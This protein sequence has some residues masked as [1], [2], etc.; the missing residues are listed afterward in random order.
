[1]ECGPVDVGPV[2]ASQPAL[3]GSERWCESL[4]D[5]QNQDPL[6]SFWGEDA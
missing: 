6:N 5:A 1:M 4:S 2:E 3:S